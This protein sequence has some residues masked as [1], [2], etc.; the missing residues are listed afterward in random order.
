MSIVDGNELF[1]LSNVGDTVRTSSI[2]DITGSSVDYSTLT[3]NTIVLRYIEH[4]CN[5]VDS[6]ID[7]T[8]YFVRRDDTLD[9]KFNVSNY[10]IE[11]NALIAGV[12]NNKGH[13]YELDESNLQ[14]FPEFRDTIY[15]VY[16]DVW[17]DGYD[18]FSN[19]Y[20]FD[21][22][23]GHISVHGSLISNIDIKL[24]STY[25]ND[26]LHVNLLDYVDRSH[27]FADYV[28]TYVDLNL[29][30]SEHS[31][32]NNKLIILSNDDKSTFNIR[33]T[34][35]EWNEARLNT[36]A[37][38]N[39]DLLNFEVSFIEYDYDVVTPVLWHPMIYDTSNVSNVPAIIQP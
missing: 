18:V 27:P 38:I 13:M 11:S 3:S 24:D 39:A 35:L 21:V 32:N 6:V 7:L 29:S 15:S 37:M 36:S 22:Q 4:D 34:V 19:T 17:L 26:L 9:L 14:L 25:H 23:E 1:S 8:N 20:R 28:D 5:V 31:S 2:L 33:Y 12:F 16:L 10:E 30:N